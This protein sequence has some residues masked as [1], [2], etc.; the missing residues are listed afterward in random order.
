MRC[1]ARLELRRAIRQ[2]FRKVCSEPTGADRQSGSRGRK[3]P[4][5]ARSGQQQPATQTTQ[6]NYQQPAQVQQTAFV[7]QQSSRAPQDQTYSDAQ[8]NASLPG[9]ELWSASASGTTAPATAAAVFA[10]TGPA[11]GTVI[12]WTPGYW[13][14]APQGYY[15]VPGAWAWPPQIGFSLWTPG[16][17]GFMAGPHRYNYHILGP[18]RWLLR[19]Y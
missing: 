1:D 3:P 5:P 16:Y 17:W 18:I 19:R 2:T 12:L 13:S 9:C 10:A 8:P 6:Q 7:P 11:P 14:Y 4:Q 15:W